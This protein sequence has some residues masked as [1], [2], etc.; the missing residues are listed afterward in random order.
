MLSQTVEL[1][2]S[3]LAFDAELEL[4]EWSMHQPEFRDRLEQIRARTRR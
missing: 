2:T 4:Q 1:P 3:T